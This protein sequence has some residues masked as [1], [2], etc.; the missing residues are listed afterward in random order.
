MPSAE[1]PAAAMNIYWMQLAAEGD[2]RLVGR[3]KG[4][5]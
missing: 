4:E 5:K 2:E 1:E 3:E